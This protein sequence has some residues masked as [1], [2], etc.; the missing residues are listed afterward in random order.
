ML[1]FVWVICAVCVWVWM[2][3]LCFADCTTLIFGKSG[4]NQRFLW[5]N[6]KLF[7]NLDRYVGTFCATNRHPRAVLL[8]SL[9][10]PIVNIYSFVK[11]ETNKLKMHIMTS[12][13]IYGA[14]CLLMLIEKMESFKLCYLCYITALIFYINL[15]G[16]KKIKQKFRKSIS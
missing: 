7:R 15:I 12:Y 3:F 13:V 4:Y 1:V 14:I 16:F 8:L 5:Q 6:L 11:T 10:T 2:V 9:V